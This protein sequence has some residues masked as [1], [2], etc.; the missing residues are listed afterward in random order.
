MT[1]S[2]LPACPDDASVSAGPL[3]EAVATRWCPWAPQP[4]HRTARLRH[5]P[6]AAAP[7]LAPEVIAP[8]AP[9]ALAAPGR[10]CSRGRR[11]AG[12]RQAASEGTGAPMPRV[13]PPPRASPV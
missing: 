13:Q 2:V 12:R 7:D 5:R 1:T 3:R 10:K 8:L 6:T 9:R 11:V 4:A